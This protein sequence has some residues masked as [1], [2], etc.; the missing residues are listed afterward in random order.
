MRRLIQNLM[1]DESFARNQNQNYRSNQI[2]D[3]VE[4]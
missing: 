2:Y 4:T 1:K 3:D